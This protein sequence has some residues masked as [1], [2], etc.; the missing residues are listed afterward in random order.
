MTTTVDVRR[1]RIGELVPY[2]LRLGLL[3]FG[4]PV[5]LVGPMERE[6]V[7]DKAWLEQGADARSHRR[8]P[9]AARTARDPSRHLYQLPARWVLGRLGRRMGFHPAELRYRCG[10]RRALRLS[11]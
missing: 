3:G 1:G 6:L 9:I 8:L 4:G 11:R 2:F 10:S 7:T 5:A